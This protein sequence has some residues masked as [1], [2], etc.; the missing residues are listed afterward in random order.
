MSAKYKAGEYLAGKETVA[1]EIVCVIEPDDPSADALYGVRDY[2]FSPGH[3]SCEHEMHWLTEYELNEQ[4]I[5]KYTPD[6]ELW[7]SIKAGDM[8]KSGHQYRKVLARIDEAVLLSTAPDDPDKGKEVEKLA[9]QL[10]ELL[11]IEG[12]TNQ[13]TKLVK[14]VIGPRITSSKA[15]RTAIS[16]WLSI[17]DLALR[18][19]LLLRG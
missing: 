7:G 17:K 14:D 19:W 9:G 2:S 12:E 16:D 1:I 6:Y 5:H 8:V 13:F 15:H 4:G 3:R 18:N 10:D 11:E